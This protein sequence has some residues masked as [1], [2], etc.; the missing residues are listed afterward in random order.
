MNA[1]IYNIS[2]GEILKFVNCPPGQL[3]YQCSMGQTFY[4]DCT[5]EATHIIDNKPITLI[6]KYEKSTEELLQELRNKRDTLLSSSD[7]SQLPDSPLTEEQ[8]QAWAEYRQQLRD[9][10]ATVVDPIN[11]PPFPSKPV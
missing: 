8:K 3:K 9:Y 4:E 5:I 1:A 2:T 11:P 10:P 6:H 7:F